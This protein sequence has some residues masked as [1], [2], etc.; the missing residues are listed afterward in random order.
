MASATARRIA[1]G[2]TRLLPAEFRN[3]FGPEIEATFQDRWTEPRGPVARIGHRLTLVADLCVTIARE[4]RAETTLGPSLMQNLWLDLK[5]TMR[6]LWRSP[7]FATAALLTLALGVGATTAIFSLVDGVL[8]RPLPFVAPDRLAFITREGDVSL[9]DGDDW[10]ARARGFQS[11]GL[12]AR[13]WQFDLTGQGEPEAVVAHA[14]EPGF[15]DVLG[16]K[17]VR[18]RLFGPSENRPGGAHLIVIADAF[19]ARHFRRDPA[20]VGQVLTLS[21]NPATIIGVLPPEADFLGDGV[22]GF[23][24]IAV[25]L[26]WAVGNRGT[27]NLDAIGRLRSD[28]PFAQARAELTA[29]SRQLSTEYPETNRGKI[30]DPMPMAEFLVGR[31]SASLWLVLAAVATLL[32]IAAVNLAG[33]LLARA[34]ARQPELALR[35]ALGAGRGRLVGQLVTE[36]VAIALAG[37]LLGIVAAIVTHRILL[38]ALPES[39]PR[40]AGLA[41]RW[42]AVLFGAGVS[43]MVGLLCGVI[44]AWQVARA[45]TIGVQGGTG[46]ARG[47]RQRGLRTIVG[48][49]VALAMALLV[50]AGLL[51]K[52]FRRLWSEPLG[53]EP[54]GVLLAELVLPE[55]RYHTRLPQS[56][57]FSGIVDRLKAVPGVQEASFVTTGPLYA[58][59]GIGTRVLFEGRPDITPDRRT[60]ARVRFTYGNHFAT[61]RIPITHGRPLVATDDERAPPVAVINA[62]MAAAFFAGRDPVGQRIALKQWDDEAKSDFWVTIV[63]VAGDIKGTSLA[64]GDS[65]AVYVPYLQRKIWWERFGVIALRTSGNPAALATALKQAVWSVDPLLTINQ[66]EALSGRHRAAAGRERFLAI[67]IGGFAVLS[68]LLVVQGLWSVVAYAVEA[69]RREFGVRMALGARPA[70]MVGLALR[71]AAL[72]TGV[73]VLAGLALAVGLGRLL[74]GVLYQVSATDPMI[75]AAAGVLLPFVAMAAAAVPAWRAARV[76]PLTAIRT[77]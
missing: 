42:P 40:T 50:G 29:V 22:I 37:G 15:F 59:G 1:R 58:R 27:N 16:V 7:A 38:G 54:S 32:T 11:I 76:D 53:F 34:A 57:A 2:L 65:P 77:E 26:P 20:A 25:E 62:A 44:P 41:I 39:V 30:V 60:G 12:F 18:G 66:V 4:H 23:V 21:G 73:G 36:G 48:V 63:G 45:R 28:V 9:P 5:H 56:Q 24:P 17:P 55:S 46:S 74:R 70:A 64:E 14:V 75:L 43:M 51:T 72:P 67:V 52:S 33:L 68:L 10:R 69:R 19:W 49:E 6:W 13:S 31:V 3:D 47:G 8:L 61:L 71:Q 35:T